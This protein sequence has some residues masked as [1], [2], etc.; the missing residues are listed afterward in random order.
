MDDQT[1]NDGPDKQVPPWGRR[2]TLVVPGEL[3]WIIQ[4]WD[5]NLTSRSLRKGGPDKRVL[6]RNR[7]QMHAC[8]AR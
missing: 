3:G 2:G 1:L 6:P 8:R 5:A 7:S 4:N